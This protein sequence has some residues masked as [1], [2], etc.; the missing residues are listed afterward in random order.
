MGSLKGHCHEKRVCGISTSGGI[1]H[2]IYGTCSVIDC[3]RDK[4]I[5]GILLITKSHTT[6]GD[7]VSLRTDYDGVLSV[8]MLTSTC[9]V[10]PP[11][12]V[13]LLVSPIY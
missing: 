8:Y 2:N 5:F 6:S 10:T 4:H 7:G 13:K 3:N 11:G 12:Q 9:K 1:G